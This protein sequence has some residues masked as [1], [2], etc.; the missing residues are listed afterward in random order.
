MQGREVEIKAADG[1]GFQAYMSLPE[2]GTGPGVLVLQEI[3]G[4]NGHIRAV[5]DYFAE[6]GYVTLAPDMFWRDEPGLQLGYGEA[7]REKAFA[8]MGRFDADKGAEDIAAAVAYLRGHEACAGGVG[9]IGFCLGGKLAYLAATRAGVDCAIGYYGVGIEN[10]L[11]ELG[12]ADC[13]ILLHFAGE[14]DHVPPEAVATIEAACAERAET[15]IHSYPGAQHGFNCNERESHD[16]PTAIMAH[17]RTIALLRRTLGPRYDLS[18]LWD[19][20]CMHEFGTRDAQAT[21]DTM[22]AEPYVNHIPTLTG[23]VG[24]QDLYRFYK[25]HF[26]PKTP[27]DTSLTPISR[28]V[29]ADRV[30]DEMVFSFTHDI[31]IDWMLPGVAPTGKKVEVPLVAII[32]FRGGRLYNEHIYWDQASVLAQIGL[33]DASSLPIAGVETARKVVDETL[34]SNQLMAR[35][36]ESE[37][38]GQG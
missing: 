4:V 20:H 23:G 38:K 33:L 6:E 28:T 11:D 34:P 19:E 29:G 8:A 27:A 25:H 13:P 18:A 2:S 15:E 37:G 10:A 22:V 32:C 35:W 31:E 26:I 24:Y 12:N 14:D 5:C 3:F 9:A 7:D 30:V 16:R 17:S 36:A 21:M 1:G